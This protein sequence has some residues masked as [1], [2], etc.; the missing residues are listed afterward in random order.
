MLALRISPN[1]AL[2][3][4]AVLALL[5]NPVSSGGQVNVTTWHNDNW[6]T[7]QN[8]HE[9]TLTTSTVQN[10]FGLLCKISCSPIL[11]VNQAAKRGGVVAARTEAG[12]S[13][14]QLLRGNPPDNRG[15][16]SSARQIL[17]FAQD[18]VRVEGVGRMP[19][20]SVRGHWDGRDPSTPQLLRF[21]NQLLRSG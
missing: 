16:R 2:S 20:S 9:T 15:S 12:P 3:V 19:R 7:G 5:L 4:A 14:P 8:T 6:R 18:D 17:R 13:T 11:S 10:N 21:A 1:A